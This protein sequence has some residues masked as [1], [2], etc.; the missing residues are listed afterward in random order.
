MAPLRRADWRRPVAIGPIELF[1]YSALTFN[2]HRIHYDRDYATGVEN[3]PGLVVHGPL[4]ATLLL[5]NFLRW[6]PAD[7]IAKFS[8]RA[9]SPLFDGAPFELFATAREGS[10][11]VWAQTDSAVVA[12]E[13]EVE[14]RPA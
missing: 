1:R 4:I 6:R 5:D 8:Y 11:L 13:G 2:A 14:S 12:M 10:A 7:T 3:Y 9:K